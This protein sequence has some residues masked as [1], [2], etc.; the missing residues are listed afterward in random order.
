MKVKTGTGSIIRNIRGNKSLPLII[1]TRYHYNDRGES[2]MTPNK[3]ENARI[4]Q[5]IKAK[6]FH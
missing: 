2:K 3:M 4:V 1:A 6:K 5:S